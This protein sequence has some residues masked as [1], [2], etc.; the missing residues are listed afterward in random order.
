MDFK[1]SKRDIFKMRPLSSAQCAC[2]CGCK[3]SSDVSRLQPRR[4]CDPRRENVSCSFLLF[5]RLFMLRW[6]VQKDRTRSFANRKAWKVI[7]P[8][9][10]TTTASLWKNTT[11]SVGWVLR[12][13]SVCPRP[14]FNRISFLPACLLH[15][16]V[17]SKVFWYWLNLATL[18]LLQ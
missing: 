9:I 14:S 18:K 11:E 10:T 1:A 2:I 6:T 3:S 5:L 16:F 12:H 13:V 4:G 8:L 7:Q 17:D 15:T